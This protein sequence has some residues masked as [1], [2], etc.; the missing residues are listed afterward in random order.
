MASLLSDLPYAWRKLRKSPGFTLTAVL[1]L[2]LGIG[3]NA[4]MFSVID[5]V[6]LRR[7]PYRDASRLVQIGPHSPEGGYGPASLPDIQD[8]KVRSHSFSDMAWW[9][10]QVPTLG[11]STN[12]LLVAQ[13]SASANLFDVL[14]AQPVLGR[15]FLPDDAKAGHSNV[16]LLGDSVWKQVFHSDHSVIGRTVP[17]NGDPYTVIGVMPPSFAFPQNEGDEIFSPLAENS[18]GFEDRGS[19]SLA[20]IAR[21]RPGVTVDQAQHEIAGIHEQLL[22]DYAA[23][24]STERVRVESYQDVVTESVRPALYALDGAVAAVWL[25]ACANIAGLMLTRASNRRRELAIREALGAGRSRLVQQF[26]TESLILSLG[27]GVAGLGVAWS[28]LR[29]LSHYLPDAV[30]YGSDIHINFAACFYLLIASCFS[31]LLFGVLP[32]LHSANVPVQEGLRDQT[33]AAGTGKKQARWRDSL[34]V[35]EIGLT[36]VLLIASGLMIRSLWQLRHTSLGFAPEHVLTTSIFMPTHG[37]WW[38]A[39]SAKGPNL[40]TQFYDPLAEKLRHT[41]GIESVGLTTLRP[42]SSSHFG[43]TVWRA[44]EPRPARKDA[45]ETAPRAGNPDYFKT[46]GI[47]LLEGRG[48]T[49]ADRSGSP[50]VAVVNQEFV[51]RILRGRDP[52]GVRLQW[53]DTNKNISATIVGVIADI[54][55]DS[56]SQ[57]SSPEMYFDLEQLVPGSDMYTVLATFHMDVAVRTRLAPQAAFNTVRN[58][59]HELE[60]ALALQEQKTMQQ[61][62]E[63]SL[64]DQTLAA[65]LLSIFGAAALLIAVTG[66]YGLLAYSVSQRTRELGLRMALGAQRSDVL[67]LV[68]RHALLLLATGVAVGL[69]VAWAASGVLRSLIYG[70]QGYDVF[71]VLLIA[72]VLGLCGM[73][74]SWLPARRASMVDPMEALR[75]E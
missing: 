19:A 20:A 17:I 70:L 44:D 45:Q 42:F 11:G 14:S 16:V 22:H 28:A 10:I 59:V 18:P 49:D 62:V 32:G 37:E 3:M 25:I 43:L 73:A 26:L 74:A 75:A 30:P 27:G 36:L 40:V 52:L 48:F 2:G 71:T 21:L 13:I 63:D 23:N 68:M 5:Q 64:G 33:A 39:T 54:H 72:L 66:L 57:A 51:R 6:L 12:P 69:G 9:T 38:K 46:M 47:V 56:V 29:M 67:W 65:R 4:A 53:D 35:G 34:V 24:E 50:L 41:P 8:W 55:Q 31:A 60:P 15:G 58:D 1:T 7:L 61:V